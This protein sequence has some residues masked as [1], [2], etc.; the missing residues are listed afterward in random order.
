MFKE[1]FDCLNLVNLRSL[2]DSSK[3]A[4][5]SIK[6]RAYSDLSDYNSDNS[7]THFDKT[8]AIKYADS[9]IALSKP[10]SFELLYNMGN[11]QVV[12]GQLQN[13]SPYYVKLLTHYPLTEH[14]RAMVSTGLS[15]F[16]SG[17]NQ[18]Q[19]RTFLMIE[20]AINV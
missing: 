4:F 19:D 3:A 9:A 8:E 17:P 20:G 16:Y 14:Q 11:K 6:S 1:T 2:S 5:Y 18:T 13:P 7:Y 10:N 15:F 12:S